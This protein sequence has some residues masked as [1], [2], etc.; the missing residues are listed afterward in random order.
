M[1]RRRFFKLLGST[2]AGAALEEAIPFGRV[3]S[4][5]SKIVIAPELTWITTEAL[6]VLRNQ[7]RFTKPPSSYNP[8]RDLFGF[9]AEELPFALPSGVREIREI[10]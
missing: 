8:H 3:W 10:Y 1:E 9:R 4:F 7:L 5:P 2:V 6:L